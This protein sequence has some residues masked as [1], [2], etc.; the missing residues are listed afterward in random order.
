VRIQ[1]AGAGSRFATTGPAAVASYAAIDGVDSAVG[2]TREVA[3]IGKDAVWLLVVDVAALRRLDPSYAGMPAPSASEDLPVLMTAQLA[4]RLGVVPG[5]VVS[6][7]VRQL[8]DPVTA[9][10]AGIV[11][12]LPTTGGY[13]LL[14][15]PSA[16]ATAAAAVGGAPPEI[17]EVWLEA[18][19]PAR[20][21]AEARTITN[22]PVEV[23]TRAGASDAAVLRVGTSLAW[24]GAIAC[25]VLA[26]I[27]F[28]AVAGALQRERRGEGVALRSLGFGATDQARGRGVELALT[29]ASA[30]LLGVGVGVLAAWLTVPA[31]AGEFALATGPLLIALSVLAV[32]LLVIGLLAA[33]RVARDVRRGGRA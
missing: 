22:R 25:L 18:D 33:N 15:E 14:V 16:L 8:P 13:G 4:S 17:N 19:E 2:L 23:L 21:A 26:L 12:E 29:A 3:T 11:P 7:V 20:V 6:V 24:V 5:D 30:I 9:V 27:G 31:L 1:F 32:G 28:A 10:V